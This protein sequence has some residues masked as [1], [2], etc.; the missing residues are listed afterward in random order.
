MRRSQGAFVG[1][2]NIS[3]C[4]GVWPVDRSDFGSG[5]DPYHAA[6]RVGPWPQGR[7]RRIEM[8][9]KPLITQ[10]ELN[11]R[12]QQSL[13]GLPQTIGW[14]LECHVLTSFTLSLW[15]LQKLDLFLQVYI[16]LLLCT[17]FQQKTVKFHVTV[18]KYWKAADAAP[19]PFAPLI[20][21]NSSTWTVRLD[22]TKWFSF[23]RRGLTCR[24]ARNC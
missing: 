9:I 10:L 22:I 5:P 12:R 7:P 16:Y 1:K 21:L 19:V 23:P 8:P 14:T 15:P 24:V 20:D 18:R 2:P 11:T 3:G 17:Y 13:S 6:Y 4:R